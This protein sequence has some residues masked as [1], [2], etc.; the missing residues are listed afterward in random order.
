MEKNPYAGLCDKCETIS[1]CK[2]FVTPLVT[3]EELNIILKKTG[4]RNFS[5]P[6]QI[7]G[8]S[9]NS[10][11]TKPSTQECVFLDENQRC[12]IYEYRPFDC[13]IFP[14]DIY[15][16]N[17]EF[18][19]VIYTCNKDA[20]WKWTDEI[21]QKFEKELLIPEFIKYLDA[22]SDINRMKDPNAVSYEHK[23]L[24]KVKLR[25]NTKDLQTN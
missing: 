18:T 9:I 8:L 22:F 13:K 12:S 10:L 1:C 23:I 11:K 3:P 19:W 7:N 15:K 4:F 25:K 24:R 16:I 21:L 5:I 20:N 17:G 2:D 6:H 14:F